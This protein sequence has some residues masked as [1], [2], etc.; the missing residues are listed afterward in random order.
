[1]WR[2]TEDPRTKFT[3]TRKKLD[4]DV[5]VYQQQQRDAETEKISRLDALRLARDTNP[6]E[7]TKPAKR[8]ATCRGGPENDGKGAVRKETRSR[9]LGGYE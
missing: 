1:V 7:P 6:P 5:R 2:R 9:D 8:A 4:D 3:K